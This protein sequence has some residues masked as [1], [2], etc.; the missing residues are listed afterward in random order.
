MRFFG[1]RL[2][3]K[4]IEKRREKKNGKEKK[5]NIFAT[6]CLLAF[7]SRRRL[8]IKGEE[9]KRKTAEQKRA[10]APRPFGHRSTDQDCDIEIE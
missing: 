9:Q 7:D 3:R 2:G 4:E 6:A 5:E 10:L 8:V 1:C